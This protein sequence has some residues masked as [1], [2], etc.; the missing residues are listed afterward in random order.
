MEKHAEETP[1]KWPIEKMKLVKIEKQSENQHEKQ[2]IGENPSM[3][4]SGGGVPEVFWTCFD[5]CF[6]RGNTGKTLQKLCI[7]NLQY[8]KSRHV[9]H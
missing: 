2:K 5:P 8:T 4:E 3:H 1:R 9:S 6:I 7:E